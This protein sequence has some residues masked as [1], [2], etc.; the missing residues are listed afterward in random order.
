MARRA[1]A[2]ALLIDLD[3]VLRVWDPEPTAAAERAHGLPEGALEA[4]AFEWGRLLPAI[5]GRISHDEWVAG[6]REALAADHPDADVAGAVRQWQSYC[7]RIDADV[8]DFVREVRARGIPVAL[9]TNATDRL[10]GDLAAHGVAAEFDAIVS[11]AAVGAHKPTKDYFAA[12]CAAVD[13]APAQC[14]F[15][16]DS[17]RNVRGARVAG[18]NAYRWNG[19]QDLPYLRA[20]LGLV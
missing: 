2:E 7:G 14:L 13:K 3:G 4:A 12:A 9:T 17:D 8:L 18:L 5:T 19:S 10:G 11:T 16:D 15:V 1:P 20:A 6:V